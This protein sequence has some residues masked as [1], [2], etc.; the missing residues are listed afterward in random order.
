MSVYVIAQLN[1]IDRPAYDRYQARFMGALKKFAGRLLAADEDAQVLEGQWQHD[2]VV[3]LSFADET[4]SHMEQFSRVSRDTRRPKSG[5]GRC[6]AIGA[7]C[8]LAHDVDDDYL[9]TVTIKSR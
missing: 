6:C 7:R 4:I 8:E 2:K 9:I 5:S 3:L 1:F